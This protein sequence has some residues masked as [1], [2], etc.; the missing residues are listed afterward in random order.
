MTEARSEAGPGIVYVN[1]IC[2]VYFARF[3]SPSAWK[4]VA[5]ED[6]GLPADQVFA[7]RYPDDT[8]VYRDPT[9][10]LFKSPPGEAGLGDY[11]FGQASSALGILMSE[12]ISSTLQTSGFIE[13]INQPRAA[14][15]IVGMTIRLQRSRVNL[16]TI[17]QEYTLECVSET[18]ICRYDVDQ[19]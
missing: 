9:T 1:K 5:Q 15:A 17:L 19:H 7:P 16:S 8:I 2:A 11:L 14:F 13:M 10:I 18:K 12:Q 4:S 6:W 3:C